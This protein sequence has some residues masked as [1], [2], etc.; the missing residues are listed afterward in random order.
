M[1]ERIKSEIVLV[2]PEL[3]TK[4]LSFNDGNRK[5]RQAWVSYLENVI[6]SGEWKA[7]HQGI[8][9]SEAGSLLDGQ[10]R[11]MAIV[12]AGIPVNLLVTYG[13]PD[14]SFSVI[15]SGIKRTDVDLTRLPKRTVEIIK[16][17]M[18]LVSFEGFFTT[19]SSKTRKAT[20]AQIHAYEKVLGVFCDLVEKRVPSRARI[21]ST[22]PVV[23]AAI[24]SMMIGESI[25]YVIETYRQ[26]VHGDTQDM[27]PISRSAVRQVLTGKISIT[28]GS[29][30]RLDNFVRFVGVFK[31]SNKNNLKLIARD[32]ESVIREVCESLK[33]WFSDGIKGRAKNKVEDVKSNL[34]DQL[35]A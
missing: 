3:A 7:T 23:S 22:A 15:D 5:V 17:F 25:D 1:S 26:L 35:S 12:Q 18:D 2:T 29:E 21:F 20:P 19:R 11:L 8:A 33:P 32:R 14:E 28:G 30:T 34:T 4:Y 13:L 9:F 24:Y 31:E 10:H 16:F 6:K 27:Y